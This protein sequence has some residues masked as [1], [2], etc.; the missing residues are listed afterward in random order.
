[1]P[2]CSLQLKWSL[3]ALCFVSCGRD[4]H[5]EHTP[6][7]EEPE[8]TVTQS[9]DGGRKP[10]R[11]GSALDAAT[12][13]QA[14]ADPSGS[15]AGDGSPAPSGNTT[16]DSVCATTDS[17]TRNCARDWSKSFDAVY[18]FEDGTQNL[19]R[20]SSGHAHDLDGNQGEPA[21]NDDHVRGKFSA[22]FEQ[23]EEQTESN[24]EYLFT[25]SE[26]GRTTGSP[27]ITFGAWIRSDRHGEYEVFS[28]GDAAS[29][30][31]S[32][33]VKLAL[34]ALRCEVSGGLNLATTFGGEHVAEFTDWQHVACRYDDATKLA[35]HFVNGL[36]VWPERDAPAG[37]AEGR[38]QLR[39]ARG[40]NGQLDE[41]FFIK[42]ALTD[43]Q[44]AR[45]WACGVNGR[46][47]ACSATNPAAYETCGTV[48]NC[49]VAP[50][51]ACNS[52]LEP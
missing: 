41:V 28:N 24:V 4:F 44:I 37:L 45:I 10:A 27:S 19:G 25:K 42:R 6:Q 1:M 36:A 29:G 20:D 22:W 18:D 2:N 38:G 30:G 7:K 39:L 43:A 14:E 23:P 11:D 12:N 35:Q 51:P 5:E 31:F 17:G 26:F 33:Y 32:M 8:R 49:A 47:C 3:F 46:A 13:E 16:E 9:Q 40:F 48:A 21:P 52:D 34:N 15:P 50:F